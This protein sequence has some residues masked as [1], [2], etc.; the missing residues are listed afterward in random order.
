MPQFLLRDL[1]TEIYL[2]VLW[3]YID[4]ALDRQDKRRFE[5]LCGELLSII[6]GTG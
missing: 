6:N 2:E 1:A 5:E 4:D 3:I